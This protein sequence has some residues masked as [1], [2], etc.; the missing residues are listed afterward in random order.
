M[1]DLVPTA[2]LQNVTAV[3]NNRLMPSAPC[4]LLTNIRTRSSIN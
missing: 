2:E 3:L 1:I 4:G